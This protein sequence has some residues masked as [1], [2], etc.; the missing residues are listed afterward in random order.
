[1]RLTALFLLTFWSQTCLAGTVVLSGATIYDGTDA[2]PLT[3]AL[4]V[5][6]S[7]KIRCVGR[8][9]KSPP[10]AQRIDVSGK[11][12]TPGLIDAHVHYAA[13]GWYDT[14]QYW[15]IAQEYYDLEAAQSYLKN[16]SVNFDRSYL[17]SGITAVMDVGGFEWTTARQQG[18]IAN[19]QQPRYV[20]A[21]PLLTHSLADGGK[22]VLAH[23]RYQGNYEFLSIDSNKQAKQSV[24][25]VAS[26]DAAALKVWYLPVPEAQQE[27]MDSRLGK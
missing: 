2:P 9:C 12:I 19:T 23:Q 4:I 3:D 16:N 27:Q 25:Y 26:T 11:Y 13:S 24:D 7:G 5:I 22:F 14:R 18:S 21:G 17:C 10:S 1:M 8:D 6:D 15:S 20:A